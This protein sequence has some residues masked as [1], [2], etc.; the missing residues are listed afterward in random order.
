[1]RNQLGMSL[2]TGLAMAAGAS[3]VSCSTI[4]CGEGTVE[5]DG[6]CFPANTDPDVAECAPGTV[7]GSMGCEVEE[8]TQCDPQTTQEQLD[9]ETGI[10]TCV[11]TGGDCT[12]EI[13]C[14]A[15]DSNKAS[16]CG[17]LWDVETDTPLTASGTGTQCAAPFP[18]TGPC[19]IDLK[20]Y[21]AL[22]FAIDPAQA[23]P[24][25][26]EGGVYLDDCGR[27]RGFNMPRANF[28]YI[29]IATDDAM[30]T[31][32]RHRLTGV[33]T[34]NA[35][36]SPGTEFRA[37]VTKITTD[38]LWTEGLALTGS[39]LAQRGVLAITFHYKEVPRSGVQVRRNGALIPNDDYYFTD[40]DAQRTA[41]SLT[42]TV[43]G[44]NGTVLVVNSDKA[45]G[46]DG[47]GGEPGTCL[48]PSNLAAA[49]PGVVFVQ[50]KEAETSGGAACP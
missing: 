50:L 35:F 22:D 37:Y 49:I 48:W 44:A 47:T 10:T 46:H 24:L 36:A 21:D 9:P 4:D 45:I 31:A 41:A 8:P 15:P 25:T 40:L 17:R 2:L 3:N 30:D 43:T 28:G 38:E 14:P 23:V 32:D 33:A 6:V 18:A 12:S 26:P 34:S 11:G 27:Y 7:L 5:R 13:G 16:L 19:S 42:P 29:G 1:M 39:T 20:F